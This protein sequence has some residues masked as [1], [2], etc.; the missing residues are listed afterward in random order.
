MNRQRERFLEERRAQLLQVQQ[1]GSSS[2]GGVHAPGTVPKPQH[3]Q[4]QQS[5][6]QKQRPK[7]TCSMLNETEKQLLRA[8]NRQRWMLSAGD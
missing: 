6:S 3:L 8:P 5:A 1:E 7:V 4:P 2:V